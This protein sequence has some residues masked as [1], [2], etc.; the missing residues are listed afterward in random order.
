MKNEKKE[1]LLVQID[2]SLNKYDNAILSPEKQAKY[3][4]ILRVSGHP[5]DALKRLIAA[6]KLHG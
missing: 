3:D 1:A 5:G 4:E 6:G 2:E